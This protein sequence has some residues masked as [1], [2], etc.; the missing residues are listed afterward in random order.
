MAL[1][2]STNRPFEGT[3]IFITI[4]NKAHSIAY[5]WNEPAVW[6]C[7]VCRGE[8]DGLM[9]DVMPFGQM[10]LLEPC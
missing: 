3:S 1:I 6:K 5:S 2:Y 8:V 9:W 4:F 10:A 7:V